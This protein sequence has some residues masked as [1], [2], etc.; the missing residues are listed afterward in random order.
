VQDSL[1]VAVTV[2]EPV[3]PTPIPV[4]VKLIVTACFRVAGLGVLEVILMVLVALA[5]VVFCVLAVGAE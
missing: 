3:G 5:A 4:A 1:V 2:T